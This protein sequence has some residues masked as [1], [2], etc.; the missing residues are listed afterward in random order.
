MEFTDLNLTA[1]GG[2]SILARTARQFGLFELLDEAVRVK[3]RNRGATDTE[4]LWALIA[5]LARGDGAL[6][7]LDALRADP[8]ARILL[9]LNRVPEA[10]RAGEWLARLQVGDVKGLWQ[11]ARRFAERVAPWIVAH[12]VET[13]G[14]VPLFIDATGIEV[15]GALFERARRSYAGRRGYW[16]HATFLGGLWSAGQLCPGGGRVTL[17]AG[18]PK[19]A[20]QQFPRLCVLE[21][22]RHGVPPTRPRA[23][24]L[25]QRVCAPRVSLEVE[26][27]FDQVRGQ[28]QHVVPAQRRR[29][30]QVLLVPCE[31]DGIL[32]ELPIG[33]H[34]LQDSPK[35]GRHLVAGPAHDGQRQ[36]A[37][38]GERAEVADRG[39]E[40]DQIDPPPAPCPPHG[41]VQVGVVDIPTD[42]IQQRFPSPVGTVVPPLPPLGG[43][44]DECPYV[45]GAEAVV[46]GS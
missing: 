8:V 16:L 41:C 37:L 25:G 32:D 22:E 43:V 39:W 35:V 14:Y 46:R 11:A 18:F 10:R 26:H 5:C 33:R 17:N 4:T 13:R 28:P 42:R 40:P 31:F 30:E 44:E 21:V 34:M 45:G 7:D 20:R 12:E 27:R 36:A 29:A 24:K 6:S 19:Q 23:V 1:Y 2:S 3:S 38:A 15:D 9:G